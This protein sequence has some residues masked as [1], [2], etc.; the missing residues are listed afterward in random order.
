MTKKKFSTYTKKNK[1]KTNSTKKKQHDKLE[2]GNIRTRIK[3]NYHNFI[4]DF[5]N[6]KIR[7][8]F[9]GKQ[10]VKFRKVKLEIDLKNKNFNKNLLNISIK[11]FLKNKI[12]PKFEYKAEN[13]NI[14]TLER[15]N[16]LLNNYLEMSYE[17]F[18]T[19]YFLK[20]NTNHNNNTNNLNNNKK[21]VKNFSEFLNK[22][23]LDEIKKIELKIFNE[24]L[25]NE[26]YKELEIYL[27]KIKFIGNNY[28]KYYK[29]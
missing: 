8:K 19:N 15:I 13:Q 2:N 5:L 24:E 12:S 26:K 10:I 23:K 25:K 22:I 4:I 28:I 9:R 11:D 6:E 14:K 7:E 29:T 27:N 20:E 16:P 3:K 17:D 18:Y 21:K 1:L